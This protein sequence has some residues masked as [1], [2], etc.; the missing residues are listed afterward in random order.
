MF[1]NLSMSLKERIRAIRESKGITQ[2]E[3]AEKLKKTRSNYAYLES[4]GEKLTV[5]QLRS[6]AD[7]IGVDMVELLGGFSDSTPEMQ[8]IQKE[9]EELKI[10]LKREREVIENYHR[11]FR[12]ISDDK[13]AAFGL[14]FAAWSLER[15]KNKQASISDTE[16][17][18]PA[19]PV[20]NKGYFD[21]LFMED[22]K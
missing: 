13:L 6:I 12:G 16:G 5:E 7:A 8:R 17:T 4:R 2:E 11:V 1:V 19:K 10:T 3:L 9:N 14:A 18:T 15:S 21:D 22:D 20:Q